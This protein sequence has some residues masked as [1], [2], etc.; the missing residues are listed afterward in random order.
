MLRDWLLLFGGFSEKFKSKKIV[1]LGI[2]PFEKED[3]DLFLE[4]LGVVDVCDPGEEADVV[5][6]GREGWKNNQLDAL[7]EIGKGDLVRFYSQE[8]IMAYCISKKDPYE[9][10]RVLNEFVMNHP[11]M[12][13][14]VSKFA[15][16]YWNS[17]TNYLNERKT[18]QK[19]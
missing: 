19:A 2:G 6:V 1:T 9:N 8:M 15:I 7:I 13:Y 16:K 10:R 4:K 17:F 14:L 18:K 5:I 3:F 12:K 11:A